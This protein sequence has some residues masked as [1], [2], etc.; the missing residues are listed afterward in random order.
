MPCCLNVEQGLFSPCKQLE[1][2]DPLQVN[3]G[4]YIQVTDLVKGNTQ[5]EEGLIVPRPGWTWI[6]YLPKAMPR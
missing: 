1:R 3:R 2:N 5:A 6:G 4:L